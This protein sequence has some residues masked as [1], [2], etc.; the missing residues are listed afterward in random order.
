MEFCVVWD[1]PYFTVIWLAG[2]QTPVG[3][4]V[5][6]PVEIFLTNRSNFKFRIAGQIELPR[7][8]IPY[9]D[10]MSSCENWLLRMSPR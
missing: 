5:E 9:S 7:K 2:D 6:T 4:P 8:A 1:D 3:I 10:R